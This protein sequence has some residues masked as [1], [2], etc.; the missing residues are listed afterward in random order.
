MTPANFH[1][2][3]LHI[4]VSNLRLLNIAPHK[5]MMRDQSN[6]FSPAACRQAADL[7]I[8]IFFLLLILFAC[9]FLNLI[10]HFCFQLGFLSN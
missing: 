10:G 6:L 8:V 3:Q 4:K 5:V 2:F 9:E 7:W 1:I